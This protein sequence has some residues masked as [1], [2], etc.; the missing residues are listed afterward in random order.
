VS[1]EDL[2]KTTQKGREI[3]SF[4]KSLFWRFPAD[5]IT[6]QEREPRG[7]VNTNDDII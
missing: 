2:Q 7:K 4:P 3:L 6:G 1:A 5:F